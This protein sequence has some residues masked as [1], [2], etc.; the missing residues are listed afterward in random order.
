MQESPVPPPVPAGPSPAPKRRRLLTPWNVVRAI[1]ILI[2][3][4]EL[5]LRFILG[6]GNPVL[7]EADPNCGFLPRA[8]QHVYR[9][10]AHNEINHYHMRSDELPDHGQKLPGHYRVLFVGDSVTYGTTFVDQPKI[11]TSLLA[12]DPDIPKLTGHPV[13]ILNMSAGGWAPSNELGFLK[14]YGTFDA[15]LIIFVLNTGDLNQEFA[16][17]PGPP[18]FPNRKPF[19]AISETWNRY[20][21]HRVFPAPVVVDPGAL[22]STDPQIDKLTPLILGQL[23]DA[24]SVAQVHAARF[25]VVYSPARGPQ[26]DTA[27]YQCG[28]AMLHNWAIEHHVP[29]VDMSADY[30]PHSLEE[31]YLDN[32]HLR[33][34][35]HQLVA[36][37]LKREWGTL[38]R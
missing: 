23:S 35:A 1:L 32:I 9:F 21:K 24:A 5:G 11:F 15:D 2:L 19:C 10:F 7:F 16:T 38:I 33:P 22:A 34:L 37:R 18:G 6:L 26:W 3:L 31:V 25:A 36:A 12:A 17:Y 20:L 30:A 13:D 28:L 27:D 4:T 8:D 29:L 14:G